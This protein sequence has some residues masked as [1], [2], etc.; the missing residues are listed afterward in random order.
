MV[1]PDEGTPDKRIDTGSLESKDIRKSLFNIF[2]TYNL[3]ENK[4]R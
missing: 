1:L 3:L 4:V 2:I